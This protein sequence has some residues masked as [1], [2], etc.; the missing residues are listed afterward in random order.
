MEYW[1]AWF[2]GCNEQVKEVAQAAE[3][4]G[5]AGIAVSDHVA[6]PVG[7]KSSHP[8]GR[9]GPAA[10]T[11]HP[12]PMI[13]IATMAAVTTKLKFMTY[14]YV[15]PMRE[16]FSAAK[17]AAALTMQTENRFI[18]GVGAG[19]NEEEITLLGHEPRNRGKRMDAMLS[20]MKDFWTKGYA[21]A[22]NDFYQFPT[23]G[24]FPIPG[25]VPVWIGG[26]S[27]AALKR[28]AR[29]EGWLG[30]NYP[31]SEIEGLLTQLNSERARYES[32]VGHKP[33]GRF[34]IPVGEPN[35]VMYHQLEDW[36]V[37]G[38]AVM[39]WPVDDPNYYP[40]ENKLEAMAHFADRFI[41]PRA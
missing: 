1:L 39:A 9:Q 22:H 21:E 14:I 30:M 8:S 41:R 18:F 23:S 33:F 7:Y 38:T 13:T 12:E 27:P 20:I 15:L 40:V 5:Y 31:M 19:W 4:M 10:N 3:K 6:I 28:A 34:V 24:Q 17:Q 11:N 26:K 16:P 32:S 2:R 37:D 29:Y 36:G 35:Q 25:D